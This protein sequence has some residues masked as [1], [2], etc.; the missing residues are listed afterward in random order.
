MTDDA[1]KQ[2]KMVT[3]SGS[4]SLKNSNLMGVFYLKITSP[5]VTKNSKSNV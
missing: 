5:N 4:V 1:A 2:R 3:M